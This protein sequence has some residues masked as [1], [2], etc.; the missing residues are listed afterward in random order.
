MTHAWQATQCLP[1]HRIPLHTRLTLSPARV[2]SGAPA[3]CES[4]CGLHTSTATAA[5]RVSGRLLRVANKNRSWQLKLGKWRNDAGQKSRPTTMAF[6]SMTNS[7]ESHCSDRNPHFAAFAQHPALGVPAP[8]PSVAHHSSSSLR[9]K[10]LRRSFPELSYTPCLCGHSSEVATR[11]N[12][13]HFCHNELHSCS[14]KYHEA[15]QLNVHSTVATS[16]T[17]PWHCCRQP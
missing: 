4:S 14:P 12:K 2:P 3:N 8:S 13:V 5:W 16:Y 10:D 7:T 15:Y 11:C 6:S 1:C 17:T 9:V